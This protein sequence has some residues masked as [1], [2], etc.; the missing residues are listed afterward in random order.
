MLKKSL[1]LSMSAL[2]ATMFA[3]PAGAQQGF[4]EIVVTATKR[5]RTLQEVPVAVSVT[6]ADTIEKAQI[7]DILDLQTVVPSL[8]VTQL[9]SSGNTNFVIRGFGNGANNPGIEPSVGV[10]IDGVYRSRSAAALSD[11][12]NLQ[13]VEVLRGPQSTLFGKNASAGV[14]SVITA[15]PDEEFG[16][17][18][19]LVVGNFGQ[20]VLRGSV[21]GPLSDSV[22]YSFSAGVNQRDGFGTDLSSGEDYNERSRW[23]VRGQLLLTPRDN[24]SL[25]FIADYDEIDEACCGLSNILSGP[26]EGAIRFVGGDLVVED[27]FSRK[28]FFNFGP[29][30]KIENSGISLQ[31]DFDFERSTLTSITSFRNVSRLENADSDFTSADILG[32]NSSDT[33]IDTFTQEIRLTSTAGEKFDWMIGGF[34]FDEDVSFDTEILFGADVSA[35]ADLLTGAPGTFAALEGAIG[36]PAGSLFGQGQ[37]N[38]EAQGQSNTAS[39]IFGTIDWYVTDR[40]TVTFGLNYTQDEK[41]VFVNQI[42][43]N[44]FAQLDFV[45]IGFAQIFGALTGGAAPTPANFAM[46]P[47][48][49]AQA[50]ALSTVPCTA[51]TGPACNPLLGLQALQVLGPLVDFPNAVEDG[52]SDDDKLTWTVRFA[53]DL[54]DQVNLYASAATGF[55]ATSWNLSRDTK[56]FASQL[57]AVVSAGLGVPNLS[58]GTRLASPEEA[59]VFELGLKARFDRGTLNIAIFDQKI[60]GFQSNI[61]TGTAFSL[62][63]AGEQSTTGLEVDA[64]FYPTDDLQ[65]TFAATFLDPTYDSFVGAQGPDGPVDLSGTTPA[66]IHELSAVF[67]ATY[68]LEFS[69]GMTGF[70]RGSYMHESDVQVVE[71]ITKEIA[72][73]EVDVLDISFGVSTDSGWDFTIWGRNLTDDEFLLS[74]APGVFQAGSFS[75]YPNPPRTYGVTAKKTF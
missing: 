34:Y 16:G 55:K 48:Q 63:N 33:D 13:R 61:F 44:V 45:T 42:N 46:F 11:L 54:N 67:T 50:Q 5:E 53:F 37:G 59:T 20:T 56:P 23:N 24:L 3:L 31:A 47:A 21:S 52:K 9:Q 69:N 4:E 62:A 19:Q 1:P 65:F 51:T 71:N 66:G 12:P 22:G 14:I 38:T 30:N 70:L 39:S 75:G 57:G 6:S 74:A 64:S 32:R 10:F 60:E 41:D 17:S 36:L 27:V 58:A 25:R 15:L 18:V 28:N 72:S 35:Y 7:L 29:T 8:R 2:L 43:T 26:T 40:S 68:S 49:F 73:R